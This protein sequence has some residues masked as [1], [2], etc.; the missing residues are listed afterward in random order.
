VTVITSGGNAFDFDIDTSNFEKALARIGAAAAG[1]ALGKS[2]AAGALVLV[3]EA[4][5]KIEENF[6][7]HPTGPLK[8][9]VRV[10]RVWSSGNSATAEWGSYGIVYARI[11]E[12]GGVIYATNGP[13]LTFKTEDGAWH[14]VPFVTMPARPYM[15][16]T[17]DEHG[18][19][20]RQAVLFQL[21]KQIRMAEA[22]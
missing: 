1:E 17:I 9:S 13:Y 5:I 16:P 12:Y 7:I 6:V 19:D 8:A 14:M 3:G 4:K 18:K 10:G 11:H 20:A 2:A 22:Q 21:E 15:R